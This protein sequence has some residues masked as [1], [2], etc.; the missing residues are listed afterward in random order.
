MASKSKSRR[1]KFWLLI[2]LILLGAAAYWGNTQ[3]TRFV[4]GEGFRV[5][6][7]EETS[8]GLHFT[9]EFDSIRRTGFL[10][11]ATDGFHS[12]DGVKAFKS[13][14]AGAV[15]AR[16]NPLGFFQRRWQFTYVKV[17]RAVAQ[18]QIYQPKPEPEPQ[19]P[20]F[21][22]LLPDRVYLDQVTSPSAD[23][24]WPF[25]DEMAGFY[26]IEILVTPHGR[27]FEYRAHGGELRMAPLPN[28]ALAQTHL[29]ITR[30]AITLYKLDLESGEKGTLQ[31]HGTAGLE[32]DQAVDA[33]LA[34]AELPLV[35]WTPPSWHD[36]LTGTASGQAEVKG[37]GLS[38]D[39]TS[40]D[41]T[42]DLAGVVLSSIDFL[43]EAAGVTGK[44][45]LKTLALDTCAIEFTWNYPNV[46][47]GQID[48]E[49]KDIFKVEGSL[50]VKGEA[51][52]GTLQLGLQEAYLDW[53]PKAK[54]EIFTRSEGGYLW[55]PVQ[56]SGTLEH[57]EE[58]LSERL[59]HTLEHS[60]KVVLKLVFK[61]VGDWFSHKFHG[62][63]A[64]NTDEEP[65]V[66]PS[67]P[68][69]RPH[70]PRRHH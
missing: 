50:E 16:F 12:E 49:S 7:N 26:G 27:D 21:A 11:A 64:A 55:T 59:M 36:H 30:E 52:S 4:E 13:I 41:G 48:I 66:S 68:A 63:K 24:V 15:E 28:L 54:T 6:M 33:S 56:L 70:A 67:I 47:I 32:G 38:I 58:D 45:N 65:A 34:F 2:F 51:L 53:L 5:A 9:G 40:G 14:E 17:H 60:P 22:F 1:G 62:E 25:R 8:K 44:E 3:L 35:D 46:Q 43:D 61:K 42:L 18:I 69:R 37:S 31:L 10:T 20:W 19:K 39:G 57:P 29:L 23:V